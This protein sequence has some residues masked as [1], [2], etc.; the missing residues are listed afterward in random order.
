LAR[1]L[2]IGIGPTTETALHSLAARFDVIGVARCADTADP[3]AQYAS[4]LGVPVFQ[5][6]SMP[7]IERLVTSLTPDCVVVSSYDR[8]LPERLMRACPFV[9]VHYAP[10]PEYRGRAT[11]N[12]ALINNET[13]V[14]I[15]IHELVPQLDGGQVLYQELV[16]IM[17]QDTVTTLYEKLNALQQSALGD[18][19]AAFLGGAAGKVQDQSRATYGCTRLPD[20]GEIDWA[21]PTMKI[22]GL[23]RALA[24]P[25]PGAFTYLDGRRLAVLRAMALENP[26]RYVGRIPGRVI[27]RSRSEGW[28][29][30]LSGDGVIRL[31]EVRSEGGAA[32]PPA[33]L[34]TSVKATLGLRTVDLMQRIR[35][36]EQ[37]VAEL[38]AI[39][40]RL[41]EGVTR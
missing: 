6:T 23:I 29:D 9:N 2:L 14:A 37:H 20:D 7:A 3:V 11:V 8:I 32:V 30:V 25:F 35:T 13:H 16:P 21:A 38:T 28:V 5:D 18:A 34:M 36:L 22:D 39:V 12:W 19:V 41:G 24:P 10:L 31:L 26:P 40:A 27:G 4:R 33:T 17:P 15:S 1:V